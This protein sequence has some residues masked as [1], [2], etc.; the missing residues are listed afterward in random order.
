M[1]LFTRSVRLR[2]GPT[3]DAAAWAGEVTEAVRHT[4]DLHVQLWSRT[5]SPQLGT[6]AWTTAVEDLTQLEAADDKLMA[7]EAYQDLVQRGAAY[8]EHLPDDSLAMYLPGLPDPTATVEYAAVVTSV[9]AVGCT[10]M[11]AELGVRIAEEAG[12][13][14]GNPCSFLIGASGNYG[15]VAWITPFP[16]LAEMQRSEQTVYADADFVKIVD[17]EA[18]GIYSGDLGATVQHYYRKIM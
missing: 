9:C 14:G 5:F 10:A 1:Y 18:A 11:G 6:L 7:D 2:P 4:T 12:R 16:S 15:A 3:R 13:I 17:E 8:V